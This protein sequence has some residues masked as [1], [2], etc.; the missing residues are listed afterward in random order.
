MSEAWVQISSGEGPLECQRAVSLAVPVFQEEAHGY[1]VTVRVLEEVPGGAAGCLASVLLAVEGERVKILLSQWQGTVQWQAQSPFRP[2]HRRK[3]WFLGV[4]AFGVPEVTAWDLSDIRVE[5]LRA[6]GPGGQNVNK[7]ASA[8]RMTHLPTGLAVLAREERSQQANRKLA[9]A[10]L[11]GMLQAGA[12][13]RE[14]SARAGRRLK[15]YRLERG[16]PVR[17]I[18]GP[19]A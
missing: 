3:N 8:V 13:Q 18:R 9:M 17:V 12:E 10:R 19:L 7:V 14:A 5:T 2:R 16:N 15:H 4:E 6:T 1:E 11:H